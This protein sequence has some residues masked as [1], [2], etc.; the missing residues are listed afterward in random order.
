MCDT[1]R[2]GRALC[3]L[4]SKYIAGRK[5]RSNQRGQ[6]TVELAVVFP[7]ALFMVY[8]MIN[9]ML[10]L[11][12]C[13]RF[14]RLS[15]EAVRTMAASPGSGDYGQ[16]GRAANAS[17][18]IEVNFAHG[19]NVDIAVQVSDVTIG[20]VDELVLPGRVSPVVFSLL[21]RQEQ[22]TCTLTYHP[23][24]MPLSVF[25]VALPGVSHTRQYVIDC[26]RPGVAF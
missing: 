11:S 16:A 7:I 13:A 8:V 3:R 18:C 25:G 9:T 19:Y 1:A 21:P 2:S 5:P 6:M 20:R 15:A 4:G 26:Y 17:Q 14:D 10:Y 22:Y 23:W 24:G 12:A